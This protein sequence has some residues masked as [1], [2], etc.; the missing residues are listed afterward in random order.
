[1]RQ[2]LA[3]VDRH[4]RDWWKGLPDSE[5]SP[6][7]KIPWCSLG[8]KVRATIYGLWLDH[9]RGMGLSK[10]P[11][12][13]IEKMLD[14][15]HRIYKKKGL[16]SGFFTENEAD[17]FEKIEN[18]DKLIDHIDTMLFIAAYSDSVPVKDEYAV[19]AVRYILRAIKS[20]DEI[21]LESDLPD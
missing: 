7:S 12:L 11:I 15:L 4:A 17:D 1:M 13:N 21:V 14:C 5:K 16:E 3:Y 19:E 20:G 9:I 6:F 8:D 10:K 2:F 18:I